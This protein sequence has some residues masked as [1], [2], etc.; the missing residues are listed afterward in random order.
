LHSAQGIVSFSPIARPHPL[1]AVLLA[2][3]LFENV[4]TLARSHRARVVHDAEHQ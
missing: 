4:S 2:M 3:I 1:I